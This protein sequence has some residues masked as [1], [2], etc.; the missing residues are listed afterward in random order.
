M[1]IEQIV[2]FEIEAVSS[3]EEATWRLRQGARYSVIISDYSRSDERGVALYQYLLES[4]AYSLFVLFTDH[5]LEARSSG[6][7]DG[8]LFL[9]VVP[10][11]QV[12]RLCEVII[13]AVT[14][15]RP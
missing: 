8:K 6:R 12:E 14:S 5:V 11:D 13:R 15:W 2:C 10:K 9:G 4:R 7:F 3:E 1:A